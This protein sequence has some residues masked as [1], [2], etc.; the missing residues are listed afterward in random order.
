VQ[1]FFI[2]LKH[3]SREIFEKN[4]TNYKDLEWNVE[5]N[6]IQIRQWRELNQGL[7]T[8]FCEALSNTENQK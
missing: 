7:A 8:E 3:I 1:D 5:N 2:F 6:Y 4:K